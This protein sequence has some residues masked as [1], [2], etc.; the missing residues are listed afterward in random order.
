[1]LVEA[2]IL[3]Q[4]WPTI[5]TCQYSRPCIKLFSSIM[6]NTKNYKI[7]QE[8]KKSEENLSA[9]ANQKIMTNDANQNNGYK[10]FGLNVFIASEEKR[11]RQPPLRFRHSLG[12]PSLEYKQATGL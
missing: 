11:Y 4:A 10:Y 2:C 12:S 1:M 5:L 9:T 3:Y 6:N 7:N 8:T